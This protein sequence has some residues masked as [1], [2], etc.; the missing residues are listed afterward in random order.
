MTNSTETSIVKPK[1]GRKSKKEIEA[2]AAESAKTASLEYSSSSK[3]CH[4]NTIISIDIEEKNK[5]SGLSSTLSA[6]LSENFSFDENEIE[7][8]PINAPVDPHDEDPSEYKEGGKVIEFNRNHLPN[9]W[10]L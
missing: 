8:N 4:D 10:I 5:L 3:S 2:A 7:K 9:K 6:T 1:R